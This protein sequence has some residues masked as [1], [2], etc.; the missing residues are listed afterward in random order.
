MFR[1][2]DIVKVFDF[3][4]SDQYKQLQ[5]KKRPMYHLYIIEKC[6]MTESQPSSSVLS[7]MD[8][9]YLVSC[10][11][12]YEQFWVSERRIILKSEWD[13]I[14]RDNKLEICLG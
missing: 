11:D 7:T 14:E 9:Q 2:G 6:Y 4:P 3:E 1:V 5:I 12:R 13:S 8:N 10:Q